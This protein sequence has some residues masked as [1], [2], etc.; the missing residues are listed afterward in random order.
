MWFPIE[1]TR[2]PTDENF[3]GSYAEKLASCVPTGNYLKKSLPVQDDSF[4]FDQ[5]LILKYIILKLSVFKNIFPYKI[6]VQAKIQ[7]LKMKL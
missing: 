6:F 7:V 2:N 3:G 4:I 5:N 1:F